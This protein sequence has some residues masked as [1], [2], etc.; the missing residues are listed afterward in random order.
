M[1]LNGRKRRSMLSRYAA[2]AAAEPARDAHRRMG[3]GDRL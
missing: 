3:L 1:Q 2:S